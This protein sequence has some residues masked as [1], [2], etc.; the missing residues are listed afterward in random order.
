[1]LTGSTVEQWDTMLYFK[2]TSSPQEYDQAIFRLQNQYVRTLSSASGVIKENLKPQTLLVDFDPDRLFRMQ[3]QKSLIYNVNTEE[4]GNSKLKERIAEDLRISPVIMMNHNKIKKLD[5]T[6]ILESISEY[7]NQ[8]SVSDEVLDIPI[9]FSILKDDD[10][11]KAI[12]QQAEFNS[13]Q[14]LTIDPNQGQG[15]ELDI[16][17][18]V[19]QTKKSEE[20]QDK[21]ENNDYTEEKSDKE[22]AK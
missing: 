1:M 17:E 10:I 8:R 7:N 15:D 21:P 18:V 3:E 19:E 14:G 22:L 13:K 4:N 5:A 11:R 16:D 9:D 2:D 6:N 12:E 20:K